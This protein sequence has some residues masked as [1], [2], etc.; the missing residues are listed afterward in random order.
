[1]GAA[2]VAA[3]DVKRLNGGPSITVAIRGDDVPNTIVPAAN[4]EDCYV[5][6]NMGNLST[7][8][9]S[10]GGTFTSAWRYVSLILY[11]N[12]SLGLTVLA[13]DAT[14]SVSGAR[15]YPDTTYSLLGLSQWTAPIVIRDAITR[16]CPLLSPTSPASTPTA[17]S[18][19]TSP[20]W[21]PTTPTAREWM[22][23]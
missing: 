2:K 3:F 9:G 11:L 22:T 18:A 14:L 6:T 23:A 21:P 17:T 4:F 8:G 16:T 13:A 5:E 15:I 1:M 7:T 19:S 10:I 12:T 20:T